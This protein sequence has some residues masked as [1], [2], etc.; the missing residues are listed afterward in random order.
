M[1]GD[2]QHVCLMII[3]NHAKPPCFL[4]QLGEVPFVDM[5]FMHEIKVNKSFGFVLHLQPGAV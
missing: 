3:S 4:E 5:V 2:T 1:L